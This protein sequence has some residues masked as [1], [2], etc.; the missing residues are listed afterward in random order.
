M[1]VAKT[2]AEL[3]KIRRE[4][5]GK[6]AFVP[7]MGALHDGHLRLMEEAKKIAD[8]LI[9]SIFVNP[10]QFGPNEDYSK[11]PRTEKEDLEMCEKAGAEIVFMPDAKEIYGSETF[12]KFRIDKISNILC[13]AS[14]PG[15][16]EG[17]AQVVSILFNTVH[18]DIAIF[19]EK[20]YQQLMIMRKLTEN[21]HFPV[22]IHA[23]P[24]LREPDGLAKS[25]RN[26]YLSP[27]E[28]KKAASIFKVMKYVKQRAEQSRFDR[29]AIPTEN[30]ENEAKSMIM[31]EIPEAKIDYIEIRHTDTL[32]KNQFLINKSRVFMAIH[33]GPARLIDNMPLGD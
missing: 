1:L 16:F 31:K 7:T 29:M 30:I 26:R 2:V 24:T 28:R 11:Y 32:E 19:G 18:P 3:R 9:V 10:T 20:D 17:V 27:E 13:G 23:V 21:L 5:I 33:V 8:H 6:V 4:L 15:H 12:V 14:R 22:K 25:S